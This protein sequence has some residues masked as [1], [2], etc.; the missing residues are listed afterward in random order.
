MPKKSSVPK[1]S[2]L[3]AKDVMGQLL[4]RQTAKIQTLVAGQTVEGTVVGVK[5]KVLVLDVGVK[6]EG[7]VVDQEF[8]NASSF[9]NTLCPGDKVSA[10]VLV[11]ETITGQPLLSLRNTAQEAGWKQLE[12]AVKNNDEL[13]VKVEGLTR[14]GLNVSC[15]GI[16]GFVPASQ[17]GSGL[18]KSQQALIGKTIKVKVFDVSRSDSRAVFSEKAVSEAELISRQEEILQKIKEGERFKGKIVSLVAFG[19]FVRIEKEGIPL[20]GLV[21]L[22]EVSWQKVSD[23]ATVLE[24]GQVIDVVVIGQPRGD[25]PSRGRLALSIKR[26]QED[27]WEKQAEGL[28]LDKQV[29]GIVTKTGDAGA[30]IEVAPG[31]EGLLR[32]NKVPDGV[33]LKE[34]E[35]VDVFIEEI[36]REN[37]KIS[38]GLVLKAK[39][40]GYK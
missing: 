17:V 14:G 37:K 11:P 40:V 16:F 6:S 39:P 20:E 38:L 18:A 1:L 9:I 24:E 27:P 23:L 33:S 29:K 30:F 3:D 21:H 22:S 31:L 19:A 7:L 28:S 8:E 35:D 12:D 25:Q 34:G 13:E 36:D 32:F 26:T 4:A 2:Q 5:N 15:Q 10:T